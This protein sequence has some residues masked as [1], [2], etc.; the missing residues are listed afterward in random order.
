MRWFGPRCPVSPEED[1]WVASSLTWLVGEFGRG[2]LE[3]PPVRPADLVPA[4][5]SGGVQEAR[6]LLDA[7]CLRMGVDP[8]RVELELHSREVPD[9]HLRLRDGHPV[10]AVAFG[11]AADPVPLVA[12][13]AHELG[14]VLLVGDGRIKPDQPDAERLADLVSVYFGLGVFGSRVA[15]RCARRRPGMAL[16]L[17][18]YALANYAWQR[19]ESTPDWAGDLRFGSR[20]QLR[21]G[22]RHLAYR[23]ADPASAHSL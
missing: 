5:Y 23:A 18:A 21:R 11:H 3:L 8:V 1:A 10:I 4:G 22:L 15:A 19:G 7:I 13:I 6:T 20:V 16:P 9:G 2:P 17:Y 14:H 12:T